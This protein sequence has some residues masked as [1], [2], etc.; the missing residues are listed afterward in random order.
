MD[1]LLAHLRGGSAAIRVPELEAALRSSLPRAQALSPALLTRLATKLLAV[2][3]LDGNGEV[4]AAELGLL[5]EKQPQLMGLL[6]GCDTAPAALQA[7]AAL[8][9][10]SHGLPSAWK[11]GRVVALASGVSGCAACLRRAVYQCRA[12]VGVLS[13]KTSAWATI[14]LLAG[15]AGVAQANLRYSGSEAAARSGGALLHL[16]VFVLMSTMLRR[17]AAA[18]SRFDALLAL[19]PLSSLTSAHV[20]A[21]V[22]CLLLLPL[23][24]GG[25]IKHWLEFAGGDADAATSWAWGGANPEGAPRVGHAAWT[26]LALTLLISAMGFG[27]YAR[28]AWGRYAWF[29]ASHAACLPLVWVCFCLHSPAGG[30]SIAVPLLLFLAEGA[31]RALQARAPPLE[32]T[33][34]SLLP[35]GGV[36]LRLLRPAGL[37]FKAGQV[38]WLCVPALGRSYHP[39]AISSAPESAGVITFHV[40]VASPGGWTA[41]LRAL[42]A[43]RERAGCRNASS[44]RLLVGAAAP[45]MPLPMPPPQP[46]FLVHLD[47]P[48]CAPCQGV[49]HVAHG[50]LVAAG[51]G[52]TPAASIL[53][54]LLA[55][56]AAARAASGALGEAAHAGAGCPVR[57]A[58]RP[59]A[60]LDLVWLHN[61]EGGFSW[62]TPLLQRF[63]AAAAGDGALAEVLRVHVYLTSLPATSDPAA[64]MLHLALDALCSDEGV[65]PVVGL[66]TVRTRAG[67]PGSWRELLGTLRR[68]APGG[69]VG[70]EVFF[71]GPPALGEKVAEGAFDAG[72]PFHFESY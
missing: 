28:A 59:L 13:F 4:S 43:A 49:V 63:E 67:K 44:R 26:G 52:I 33:S 18:A 21:G 57:A 10:G 5:L 9:L 8:P 2:A 56:A 29:H 69:G 6:S 36:E 22:G 11:R 55:R 60:R 27:Y 39:F 32:L 53:G 14:L 41:A 42:L 70:T 51:V 19:L 35:S 54:S 46:P 38:A 7:P 31:A 23:H 47:G 12:R 1:Q 72:L 66:R 15:A 17:L 37:F 16:C 65:D 58:L 68:E 20:I 24:V 34:F 62:L 48:Y 30:A 40:R 71:C 50:V 45:V 61:E 25:H 3:D 64:A